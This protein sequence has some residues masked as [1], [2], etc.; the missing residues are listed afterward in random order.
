MV[1]LDFPPHAKDRGSLYWLRPGNL[2]AS[3]RKFKSD[4][5][6]EWRYV[7]EQRNLPAPARSMRFDQV[8]GRPTS[9]PFRILILGDTGEGDHS[10]YGLLPLI[11]AAHA[12]LMIINGDVAYPAGEYQD[13]VEGF[14][15]PYTGL[16]IPIWAT[17]GNHEYYARSHGQVYHDVFCTRN[18]AREWATAGL[19]LIPQPGMYWELRDPVGTCP[20]VV[21]GLDSGKKGNLDG[22]RGFSQ[23]LNP[24]SRATGADDA[25]H[26]W[27]DWRLGLADQG[28]QQV[29]V[30]YHIPAL[31]Q[32][33]HDDVHLG[34]LHRILLRHPSVRAVIC[35]HIHNHQQY[36]PV[37]FA[38]YIQQQHGALAPRHPAPHYLVSGDGG[39][40]L[41]GTDLRDVVY[42]PQDL[43]PTPAQWKAYTS[44]AREF[45]EHQLPGS[46]IT[47][48]IGRVAGHIGA[49]ADAAKLR[50]F[51]Q[52]DC[53][54]VTRRTAV[55]LVKMDDLQDFFRQR[56]DGTRVRVDAPDAPLDPGA[57]AAA[58]QHLFDL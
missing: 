7:L 8:L 29:I 39:A 54:P 5:S 17:A 28:Q 14:F 48:T 22:H 25:Q 32:G 20:L 34:E 33:R 38:D 4:Y 57:L 37:T 3:R 49:D 10:Q 11:Q 21:I 53:D 26:G 15:R 41:E 44:W 6:N 35:G 50:C 56:P 45:L 27:L 1:E 18:Y 36:Q 13:F 30:L 47:R 40:T 23:K 2:W 31:V 43:Y 9:Q 51:L 12:D 52:V 24:L 19:T 16:G 58:T 46:W 55:S 42:P